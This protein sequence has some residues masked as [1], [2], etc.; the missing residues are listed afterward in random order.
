MPVFLNISHILHLLLSN[1]NLIVYNLPFLVLRRKR[2]FFF[3]WKRKRRRK[4]KIQAWQYVL[5][6][7]SFWFPV[8]FLVFDAIFFQ[9]TQIGRASAR[10]QGLPGLSLAEEG[11]PKRATDPMGNYFVYARISR[12]GFVFGF[13]KKN[14][15]R[16]PRAATRRP[17]SGCLSRV[18]SFLP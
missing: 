7:P 3:G 15:A 18:F 4:S 13:V 1:M 9:I 10:W 5:K 2:H 8:P 17:G 6:I 12:R 14:G 16:R 11:T